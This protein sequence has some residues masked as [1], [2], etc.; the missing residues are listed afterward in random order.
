MVEKFR[1]YLKR[2]FSNSPKAKIMVGL[3]ICI[4]S[5]STILVSMRKTVNIIVDGK[6]ETFVTYRGTV[7]DVLQEKGYELVEKD[8]VQPSIQANITNDDTISVKKAVPVKVVIAGEEREVLTAEDTVE[9]MLLAES[10]N[11][12]AE[13][14]NYKDEDIV[15]PGKDAK[16]TS[17]MN[18]KIVDVQ[19]E[20]VQNME[21][22]PFETEQV[23]DYNKVNTYREV[24][25]TGATGKKAVMYKVVKHDNEIIAKEKVSETPVSEPQPEQITVGGAIEKTNRGGQTYLSKKTLY[26]EAT[27]YSGGGLTATG[28]NV[29]YDPNGISTIAVDPRVI[30]LGSLVEVSGYGLAIAS[31]T[32]GLIKGN[33][34]DVYLNTEEECESWGRKHNVEVNIKAYPGEW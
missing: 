1:E 15:I 4:I 33:I 34:I 18:V 9:D 6:K 11:L 22:I 32:G 24:T 8:K 5:V 27:A 16:I 10:D 23:V 3:I 21:D 29:A 19:Q 20:E 14:M 17:D 12:K 13:G 31:D 2:I 7:K 25:K 28:K 26:L 30:P